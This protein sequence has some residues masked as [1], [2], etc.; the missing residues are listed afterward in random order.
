MVG[1]SE[2]EHIDICQVQSS[3]TIDWQLGAHVKVIT[4]SRQPA[5]QMSDFGREMPDSTRLSVALSCQGTQNPESLAAEG[6]TVLP[7]GPFGSFL[8]IVFAASGADLGFFCSRDGDGSSKVLSASDPAIYAALSQNVVVPVADSF[9]LE[10][11]NFCRQIV[12]C[13]IAGRQISAQDRRRAKEVLAGLMALDQGTGS[14]VRVAP[15]FPSGL[16]WRGCHLD[17]SSSEYFPPLLLRTNQD[18]G[19]HESWPVLGHES[20]GHEAAGAQGTA[21]NQPQSRGSG[22]VLKELMAACHRFVIPL[23]N[24]RRRVLEDLN[25]EV[26][27][28]RAVRKAAQRYEGLDG[29]EVCVLG[30]YFEEKANAFV[31]ALEVPAEGCRGR[32]VVSTHMF[33]EKRKEKETEEAEL[34]IED[35]YLAAARE[36]HGSH[37]QACPQHRSAPSS[38]LAEEEG[39]ASQAAQKAQVGEKEKGGKKALALSAA[40]LLQQLVGT[41][42]AR[43][44]DDTQGL[45]RSTGSNSKPFVTALGIEVALQESDMHDDDDAASKTDGDHAASP[46]DVAMPSFLQDEDDERSGGVLEQDMMLRAQLS[47]ATM[48]LGLTTQAQHPAPSP[49]DMLQAFAASPLQKSPMLASGPSPGVPC[50][51]GI[52]CPAPQFPRIRCRSCRLPLIRAVRAA[53]IDETRKSDASPGASL[54]ADSMPE[55][56]RVLEMALMAMLRVQGD[57]LICVCRLRVLCGSTRGQGQR[58]FCNFSC[59]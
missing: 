50:C 15:S 26:V 52:A 48:L 22:R 5:F 58:N 31:F 46:C 24:A 44:N 29:P 28:N 35:G 23:L 13:A 51:V 34:L 2:P 40:A 25:A 27:S 55:R 37:A 43:E 16:E 53:G 42:A 18:R 3:R 9:G 14:K 41:S 36:A 11:I 30:K 38:S 45:A 21:A 32:V 4:P 12:S 7:R 1:G 19:L 6:L 54:P 33:E 8:F 56:L 20:V 57:S 17:T 59:D 39:L 49:A 10:S 47:A